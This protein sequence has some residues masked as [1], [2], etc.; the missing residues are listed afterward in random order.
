M[1]NDNG[2]VYEAGW[3]A[4]ATNE[5]LRIRDAKTG[6]PLHYNLPSLNYSNELTEGLANDESYLDREMKKILRAVGLSDERYYVGNMRIDKVLGKYYYELKDT[7]IE[8]TSYSQLAGIH[9]ALFG[10]RI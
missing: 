7:S 9:L 10:Y 8:I 5:Y 6:P 1:K 2:K 4:T 3:A